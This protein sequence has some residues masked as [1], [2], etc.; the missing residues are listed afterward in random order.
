MGVLTRQSFCHDLQD[1]VPVRISFT[2]LV[3]M[4]GFCWNSNDNIFI[5]SLQQ[6]FQSYLVFSSTASFFRGWLITALFPISPTESPPWHCGPLKKEHRFQEKSLLKCYL[7]T[8]CSSGRDL[9]QHIT[10]NNVINGYDLFFL[11]TFSD[12]LEV[13]HK[14]L[15]TYTFI[16]PIRLCLYRFLLTWTKM[17]EQ[18]VPT[19]LVAFFSQ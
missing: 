11:V 8:V 18:Q 12:P 4:S 17:P 14:T 1:G 16:S 15:S 9:P 7:W 3:R 6:N 2:Q 5:L 10:L 19:F 13:T